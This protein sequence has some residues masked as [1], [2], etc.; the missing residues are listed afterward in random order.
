M[1]SNRGRYKHIFGFYYMV[2]D[3]FLDLG[4][5]TYNCVL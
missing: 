2:C 4:I 5:Y 3:H 1:S